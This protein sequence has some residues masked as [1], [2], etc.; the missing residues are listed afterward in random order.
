VAG[1]TVAFRTPAAS[2]VS[3]SVHDV[4]GR[5]VRTLASAERMDAGTHRL[6]WD[7]R[8]EAGADL[9]SGVYFARVTADGRTTSS[10]IVRVN[11]R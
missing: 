9:P 8:S 10:K 2:T 5:R 7:G 6:S 4:A 11:T 3:V 1:T